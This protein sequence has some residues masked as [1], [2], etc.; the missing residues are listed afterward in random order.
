MLLPV[1]SCHLLETVILAVAAGHLPEPRRAEPF[2][3]GA[4]TG[5]LRLMVQHLTT[6]T[7]GPLPPF[8]RMID[9]DPRWSHYLVRRQRPEPRVETF[10]WHWRFLLMIAL[11]RQL[12]FQESGLSTI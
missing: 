11:V 10:S 9:A 12:G 2:S 4:F 3:G 7:D 5:K 6:P 1:G 8:C